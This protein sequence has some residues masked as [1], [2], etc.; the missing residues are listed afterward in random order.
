MFDIS[1]C[2]VSNR[3]VDEY[4][5]EGIELQMNTYESGDMQ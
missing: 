3:F 5:V 4:S 2:I 1:Y